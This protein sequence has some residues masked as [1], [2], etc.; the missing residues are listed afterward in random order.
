MA[1]MQRIRSD[2]EC[3]LMEDL[4]TKHHALAEAVDEQNRTQIEDFTLQWATR[5]QEQKEFEEEQLAL[6]QVHHDR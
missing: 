1:E 6:Q 3:Q 4:A 5:M 2:A